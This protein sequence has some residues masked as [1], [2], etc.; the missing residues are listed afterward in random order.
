MELGGLIIEK[1]V[2]FLLDLFLEKSSDFVEKAQ[3][4]GMCE[5]AKVN[6]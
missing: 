6:K 3:C 5:I 2:M 1:V 4:K